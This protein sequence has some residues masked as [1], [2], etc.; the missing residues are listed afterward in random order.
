MVQHERQASLHDL[1]VSMSQSQHEI[2]V[3]VY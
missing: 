2:G 3:K 1:A